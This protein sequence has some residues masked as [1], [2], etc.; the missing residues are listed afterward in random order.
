MEN[1]NLNAD[2]IQ[3]KLRHKN[4]GTQGRYKDH[5]VKNHKATAAL[6]MAYGNRSSNLSIG[7]NDINVPSTSHNYS[8]IINDEPRCKITL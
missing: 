3:H 2:V 4:V 6:Q 1:A 8:I 7:S 5:S